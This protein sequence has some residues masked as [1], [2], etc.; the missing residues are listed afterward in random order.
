MKLKPFLKVLPLLQGLFHHS[1]YL[2]HQTTIL[3]DLTSVLSDITSC[4]MA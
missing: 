4:S 2:N 1:H 3:N